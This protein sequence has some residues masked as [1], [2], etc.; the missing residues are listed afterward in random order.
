MFV[1]KRYDDRRL[2]LYGYENNVFFYPA[3][4]DVLFR[5]KI[6]WRVDD[7]DEILLHLPLGYYD[8]IGPIELL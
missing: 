1:W 3:R 7:Y 5:E 6:N 8:H 4:D 2:G